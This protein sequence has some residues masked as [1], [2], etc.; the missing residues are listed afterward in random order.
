MVSQ[1]GDNKSFVELSLLLD[2]LPYCYFVDINN[3]TCNGLSDGSA[4]V[5]ESGGVPPYSYQWDMAAGNAT[6]QTVTGLAAGTYTV[7]VMD[8]FFD[9]LFCFVTITEPDNLNLLY[10]PSWDSIELMAYGGTPPYT[11]LW[12]TGDTASLLTN[13]PCENYSFT[14]TDANNCTD[15]DIFYCP[16]IYVN[17]LINNN[18]INLNSTT[19]NIYIE[20]A[21]GYNL[22]IYN[23]TGTKLLETKCTEQSSAIDVFALA[24]GTYIVKVFKDNSFVYKKICIVK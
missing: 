14:V 20:N 19:N 21:E 23:I 18:I 5:S 17:E 13:L 11:Y 2:T 24:N 22:E 3:V 10:I 6:T 8:A 16:P 9:V 7:T 1:S 15:S 12:N 4:T